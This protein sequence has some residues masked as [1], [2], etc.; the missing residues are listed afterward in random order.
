MIRL[1][2]YLCI[3]LLAVSRL[4]VAVD[5]TPNDITLST[6]AEVNDFQAN[7]GPG[8]DNIVTSLTISGA[9]I[10]DL[11]PLSGLTTMSW[12]SK[13]VISGTGLVSLSGLQGLQNVH[14]FELL[15]NTALTDVSALSSVVEAGG[16]IFINGNTV[17][18][19]L[20]GLDNI[21]ML[22]FGALLIENNTNLSDLGGISNIQSINASLVSNNND[23]LSNLDALTGLQ[24]VNSNINISNNDV[25]TNI[26]GLSGLAGFSET[27]Y[28]RFNSQ[29]SSL[30]TLHNLT[31]LSGLVI[32]ANN[33]LSRKDFVMR[34]RMSLKEAKESGYW[35]R[36]LDLPGEAKALESERSRLIRESDE[37]VRIFSTIIQK[38]VPV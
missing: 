36:L 26:A 6:Q 31:D 15:N 1:S 38:S 32:Q 17:L 21:N 10:T 23:M 34:V 29:L 18:G 27:L 22:P 19:N 33:A 37:L 20:N 13:L 14:W 30:G 8:C 11:S 4:A 12:A 25:L 16:P 2:K 3:G 9:S 28:L 24:T 35:L 7:H 5:C